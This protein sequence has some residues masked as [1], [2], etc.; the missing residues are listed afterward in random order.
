MRV[1]VIEYGI[2]NVQSVVNA[3]ERIG[4]GTR[5]AHDGA[6]LEEQNPER[7]V[8]PGV[9]AIGEALG[10][11]RARGFDSALDRLVVDGGTPLLG[12]CVGMQMLG[13]SCEEFGSHQGLGLV[14]GRV[15]RLA[16]EGS[17][18]RLPHVGWNTIAVRRADDPVLGPLD[19]ED[20]YFVHSYALECPDEFVLATTEYGAPFVSAVRRDHIIGVQFHPEKSSALGAALL[21]AFLG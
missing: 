12:I 3:C 10:N 5:V 4:A 21:G 14:P 16:P 17:G 6:E 8:M 20:F 9:G 7:I 13:E 1:S 19:G 18:L 11:L 15:R 2:G